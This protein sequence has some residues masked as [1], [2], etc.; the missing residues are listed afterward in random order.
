MST[1]S[2]TPTSSRLAPA[3][4]LGLLLALAGA[5]LPACDSGGGTPA[6]VVPEGHPC[7][8][9]AV[10]PTTSA[11]WDDARAQGTPVPLTLLIPLGDGDAATVSQGNDQ[12]P[13]HTGR[14][15][16]A[17]D[18]DVPLGTEVH[19]A[20]PGIV[21]LVRDD[22]TASG[23][24][25]SY[26]DDANYVLLDHG[27][28]LF[29]EYVHLAEGSATVSP[30]QSV[31]AGAVLGATGLSGQ[32]SGPHL[33]FQ[34]E[35][36]WS[37][38]LPARFVGR[39]A[40]FGCTRLPATD[41]GVF[42]P[43]GLGP[44]LLG[45]EAPSEVPR[46]AFADMGVQWVEGVPAR[47]FEREVTYRLSGQVDPGLTRLYFMVLPEDGGQALFVYE[48]SVTTNGF[49]ASNLR[50]DAIGDKLPPGRYGWAMIA[51][52]EAMVTVPRSIRM[53]LLP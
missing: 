37:E 16:Y 48:S 1:P 6:R 3:A 15:R 38:T 44:L 23:D 31:A 14:L 35:N 25:D 47:L 30:G 10:P 43:A 45:P 18:F 41:D 24:D 9:I 8:D 13:T 19:A 17:W 28:G 26:A 2:H 21:T 50:L 20:A 32:L 36:L 39:T 51:S 49:F 46:D 5:G 22:S 27:G 40:P 7:P 29:T 42:R 4:A 53:T 52:T 11:L 33:H 34:V 12:G